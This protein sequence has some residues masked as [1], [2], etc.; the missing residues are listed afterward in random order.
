[1]AI[2]KLLKINEVAKRLRRTPRTILNYIKDN[3]I[4]SVELPKRKPKN[5]K[6]QRKQYLI[7]ESEVLRIIQNKPL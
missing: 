1:M 6:K 2:D 3:S 7:P 5:G 4:I